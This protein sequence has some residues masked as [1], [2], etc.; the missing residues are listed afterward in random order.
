MDS[1]HHKLFCMGAA[2][3]RLP[4]G[5]AIVCREYWKEASRCMIQA[6]LDVGFYHVL[7]A[8]ELPLDCERVDRIECT[9][10]GTVPVAA[11]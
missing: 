11:S 1:E 7:V 10:M 4:W 5:P 8:S 3:D 6:S 9:N 2:Q